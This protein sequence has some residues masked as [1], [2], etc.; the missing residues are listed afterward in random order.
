MRRAAM[1]FCC[2]W[3]CGGATSERPP[4]GGIA[5]A[6]TTEAHVDVG[7]EAGWTQCASPG[8]YAVCGGPAMCSASSAACGQCGL[9]IGPGAT[10]AGGS[11]S[12]CTNTAWTNYG[13]AQCG[14]MCPDGSVC[15]AEFKPS[16]FMCAPFELGVLFAMN[17]ATDR[18]RYADMGAWTGEALPLPATCPTVQGVEVCGGN[19]PPCSNSGDV[20][21]G[22]SP[23]H[24]YGFCAQPNTQGPCSAGTPCSAGIGCLTFKVEGSVQTLADKYG[25]CL[26]SSLCTAVA[27]GLPGGATCSM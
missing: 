5:D 4:D 26:P 14:Q 2:L 27:N 24:P 3:A 21:T 6:P 11:L 22:R 25:M 7:T 15:V 17:G 13:A 9:Y 1:Y 12:T 19:C 20:C 16:V 23:L 8:G 10:D 18:V